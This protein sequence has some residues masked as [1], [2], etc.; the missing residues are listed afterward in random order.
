MDDIRTGS[1]N[2]LLAG[3]ALVFLWWLGAI[4]PWPQIGRKTDGFRG[5][6]RPSKFV[7]LL[8]AQRVLVLV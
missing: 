3:S 5:L 8:V 4:G 7:V 1:Y 6:P 2:T